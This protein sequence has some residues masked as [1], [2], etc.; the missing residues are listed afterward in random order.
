MSC[1]LWGTRFNESVLIN[2]TFDECL[3]YQLQNV[4]WKLIDISSAGAFVGPHRSDEF[5]Q[6][7]DADIK[8]DD[9]FKWQSSITRWYM[10][11]RQSRTVVMQHLLYFKKYVEQTKGLDLSVETVTYGSKVGVRVASPRI[12]D[13][14][15]VDECL[16]EYWRVTM[17]L[18]GGHAPDTTRMSIQNQKAL[19]E[20][21]LEVFSLNKKLEILGFALEQHRNQETNVIASSTP[22]QIVI[23]ANST[24]SAQL[25]Q[26][27]KAIM[28]DQYVVEQ[29]G[30]VGPNSTATG[31]SLM[32][33]HNQFQ[34]EID[35]KV[36]APELAKLR[37]HLRKKAEIIEHDRALTAIA[38]AEKSARKGD[39]TGALKFLKEAGKWAFDA[40][41]E[42]GTSV[43]AKAIEIALGQ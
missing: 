20:L 1:D 8:F 39:A 3:L 37:S 6:P 41:T 30:A 25:E 43:A 5:Y 23:S 7:F 19:A 29:A 21:E 36:L 38:S 34:A 15:H 22:L 11:P 27:K 4:N 35:L 2:C 17:L 18:A 32:Q 26:S 10:V 14:A 40:A 9:F 13:L 31:N 42:I 33:I 16:A 24:S 28:G 12:A